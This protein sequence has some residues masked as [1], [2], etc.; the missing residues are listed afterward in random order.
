MSL[1]KC[2][3]STKY[4]ANQNR[5]SVTTQLSDIEFANLEPMRTSSPTFSCCKISK[6]DIIRVSR[7]QKALQPIQA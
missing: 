7:K 3:S 1:K 6:M 2:T 4:S 5:N